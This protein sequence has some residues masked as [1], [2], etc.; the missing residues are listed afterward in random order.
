[1]TELSY[2]LVVPTAMLIY[3][4]LRSLVADGLC[5]EASKRAQ[6]FHYHEAHDLYQSANQIYGQCI[7]L[8]WASTLLILLISLAIAASALMPQWIEW[9]GG[10][11]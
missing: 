4:I 5:R 10:A 3:V 9:I 2:L 11:G 6:R 7:R 1:M 8:A